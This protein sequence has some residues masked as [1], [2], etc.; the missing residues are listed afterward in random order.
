MVDRFILWNTTIRPPFDEADLQSVQALCEELIE[1]V[2]QRKKKMGSKTALAT[3]D[4]IIDI[5]I[6]IKIDAETFVK[7]LGAE[8]G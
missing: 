7:T 2:E 5:L 8:N 1:C 4:D 3:A 6:D